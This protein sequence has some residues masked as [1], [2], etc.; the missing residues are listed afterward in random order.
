M[1]PLRL[2]H[3]KGVTTVEADLENW[4]VADLQQAILA[5][6]EIPPSL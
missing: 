4:T 5:V 6:T 3:P 2:R 1:V